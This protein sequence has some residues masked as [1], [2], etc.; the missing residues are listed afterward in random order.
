[1]IIL[2]LAL[3]ELCERRPSLST[4][5]NALLASALIYNVFF[6]LKS[7]SH[8]SYSMVVACSQAGAKIRSYPETN[9][10]VIGRGATETTLFTQVP[11]IDVISP[12]P[13]GQKLDLYEPGWAVSWGKYDAGFL[14]DQDLRNRF[15]SV[16]IGAYPV[17]CDSVRSPLMLFRLQP[18]VR[19]H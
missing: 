10:L 6:V 12:V 1:M 14:N 19:A 2:F 3:Q 18:K 16:L 11:A 7:M 5:A 8:P 4:Y 15:D 9:Q 13:L 17:C